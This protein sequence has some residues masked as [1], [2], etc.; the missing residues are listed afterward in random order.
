MT[1]NEISNIVI[2]LAIEI[3]KKLGPGLLENVYKECLL[4][5]IKQKGLLVEKEKALPV[6]FEEVKL[7]CGYRIDLLVEN[8]LLIEIKS[9]ESL[10]VNHLAQTLTYLKLG[11]FKLGLLINFSESLLKNGVRR[12]ANNLQQ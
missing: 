5:K 9:V 7:D 2:G 3:H 12:V 6:V 8:K 1:E 4:Y 11:N 10:T